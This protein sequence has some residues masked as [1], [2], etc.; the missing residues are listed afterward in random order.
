[1]MTMTL[2]M[3]TMALFVKV[4]VLTLPTRRGASKA[5]GRLAA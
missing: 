4:M 1:M 5:F 3:L 2:T